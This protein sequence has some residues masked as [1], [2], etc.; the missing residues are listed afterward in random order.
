MAKAESSWS[1]QAAY[2]W[3]RPM[4]TVL[5]RCSKEQQERTWERTF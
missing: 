3:E 5:S 4:G 2:L 1:K